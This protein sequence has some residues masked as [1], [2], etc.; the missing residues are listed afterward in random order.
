M[1]NYE[2]K[3]VWRN[4]IALTTLHIIAIYYFCTN[5]MNPSIQWYH[6]FIPDIFGRLSGLGILAGAH[7]LWAHR[8]YRARLPLRIVLMLLQTMALQNDIYD[9][10][11]DHRVHHKYSDTDA[12]PYNV[13]RGFFFSHMGWLLVRKHPEVVRKGKTIDLT[14]LW[15]DP[16]VRFQRRFYIPLVILVWGILPTYIGHL[17]TGLPWWECFFGAVIFRYV[18]SLHCT[19]TVNSLAH[20]YGY[21]TFDRSYEPRENRLV[22]Y[23]SLG[24][25][26]HNYHH[27][28]PWDYSA[29]ELGWTKCFNIATLFIDLCAWLGLADQRKK[30][31]QKLIND[32][33]KRT[34]NLDEYQR[35]T[36]RNFHQIFIDYLIGFIISEHL[37]WITFALRYWSNGTI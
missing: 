18:Y 25:G 10:C 21:R 20:M 12:D 27:V 19:W 2:R 9:W 14:D 8:S 22:T 26:Y 5:S 23:L 29:S 3:I 33:L 32:R 17:L 35:Q 11:R 15:A 37:L 34:G 16:V 4:V 36:N 13:R 28:F 30:A 1:A 6:L 31:D 24:E 7:R